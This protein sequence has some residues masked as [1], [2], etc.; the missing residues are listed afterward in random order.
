MQVQLLQMVQ[1]HWRCQ[2]LSTRS[3]RKALMLETDKG[4]FFVKSYASQNKADWVVSLSRQLVQ[5]GFT[6]TLE[7][8]DS[9][10]G[11]SV[12]PFNGRYFVAIKPIKGRDAQ[13]DNLYD[14]LQTTRCLGEFHRHA[15]GISGGPLPKSDTIPIIDKWE[16]RLERFKMIV[17]KLKKSR[18]LRPLDKKILRFSPY[19]IQE[20]QTALDL[21]S[22]SPVIDEYHHSLEQQSVAHR[23]LASHNFLIGRETH[24][25]DY[26]TAMYDTQLVDLIQMVNRTLDQQRWTIDFFYQMM[27]QY[28]LSASLTEQQL[29]L[30]YLL[31]RYPDNFMREVIGL[32]EG[33]PAFVS[34][35]IDAY[36]TMIMKKW[37]ERMSFF[38]GSRHFFYDETHSGSQVV[39]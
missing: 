20:A 13:Y 27:E 3:R 15:K 23:D 10:D 35:K 4:S 11:Q 37:S 5:K 24:L 8:Y 22:R 17:Q 32:Y 16:N 29:A 34:K 14:I 12:V 9:R 31:L 7:Y 21:A 26:D 33:D 18:T 38:Q 19:V 28:Q 2:V 1:Q 25:I 39:V 6:E 36:L 30:V